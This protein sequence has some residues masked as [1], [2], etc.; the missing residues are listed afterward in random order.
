M[1]AGEG[2]DFQRA[3]RRINDQRQICACR[4]RRSEYVNSSQRPRVPFLATGYHDLAHS[5]PV[6][7]VPEYGIDCHL[8]GDTENRAGYFHS[9]TIKDRF[10][11][12]LGMALEESREPGIA[13]VLLIP[14]YESWPPPPQTDWLQ[15]R[16]K[17]PPP[18]VQRRYE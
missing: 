5:N 14:D 8:L 6:H 12:E 11:A 10:G 9:A 15:S 18:L 13:G 3:L 16:Q 4:L 17:L 1:L 7:G 2:R